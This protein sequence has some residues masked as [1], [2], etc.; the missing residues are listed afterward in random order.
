MKKPGRR[1]P[2]IDARYTFTIVFHPLT[3]ASC[4]S[5]VYS[6]TVQTGARPW[7]KEKQREPVS[8]PDPVS[9]P[10][11]MSFQGEVAQG[12]GRRKKTERGTRARRSHRAFKLLRKSWRGGR[13]SELRVGP[14]IGNWFLGGL[15]LCIAPH[16]S[17][18]PCH[19]RDPANVGW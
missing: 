4:Y 15:R 3:P 2:C 10:P 7:G 12:G 1:N 11:S 6:F 19:S 9:S 14:C 8:G 5:F 13:W 17:S 18:S 16:R